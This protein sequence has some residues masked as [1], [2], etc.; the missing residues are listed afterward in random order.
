MYCK[1]CGAFIEDKRKI[2]EK[3]GTMAE[4]KSKKPL[5]IGIVCAGAVLA[6]AVV[7]AGGYQY[8]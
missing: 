3:C 1:K 4:K 7:G 8:I 2:C 5:L 6:A